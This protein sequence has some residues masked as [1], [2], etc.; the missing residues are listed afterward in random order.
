MARDS[1]DN[2]DEMDAPIYRD[3]LGDGLVIVTTLVLLL[4]FYLM[5][6]NLKDKYNVGM[7]ADAG[8]AP[9]TAK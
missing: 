8:S 6:K 1:F 4:A 3:R 7:L 5:E 2:K 9:A